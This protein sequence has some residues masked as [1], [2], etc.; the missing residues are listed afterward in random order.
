MNIYLDIDGVLLDTKSPEKDVTKLFQYILKHYPETTHWLTTHCKDGENRS[1]EWLRQN[2]FPEQIVMELEVKVKPTD[3]K[4]LK[5]EAIDL[6]QPFLWL[7]DA[8][9]ESERLALKKYG[10]QDSLIIMNKKDPKSA[11]KALKDIK[12]ARKEQDD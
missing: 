6:E 11:K 1:I 4:M 9:F 5:T 2:D 8:P 7:D 12:D 10:V 3:W